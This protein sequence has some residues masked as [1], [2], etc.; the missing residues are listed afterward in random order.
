[1]E[2]K[3]EDVGFSRQR[4]KTRLEVTNTHLLEVKFNRARQMNYF[5]AV[6]LTIMY[7]FKFVTSLN[8]LTTSFRH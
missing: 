7:I 5:Q 6:H 3:H 4:S 2:I 1:M 8:K